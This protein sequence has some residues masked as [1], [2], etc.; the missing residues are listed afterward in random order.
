MVLGSQPR[1]K[2]QSPSRGISGARLTAMGGDFFFFFLGGGGG[3]DVEGYS[4][5]KHGSGK[6][7]RDHRGIV[8]LALLAKKRIPEPHRTRRRESVSLHAGKPLRT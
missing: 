6:N 7:E 8:F 5:S 1:L 3:W 2:L 4:G